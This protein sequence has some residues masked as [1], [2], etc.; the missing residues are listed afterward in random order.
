MADTEGIGQ[1]EA[2]R[3]PRVQSVAK[4][5]EILFAIS[6]SPTGLRAVDVAAQLGLAKQATYHLLHTLV[7]TGMLTKAP[8]NSYLLG[9]RIGALVEAFSK[10]L[11]PPERLTP[12]VREAANATG[13]T[14][15]A[16]GWVQGEIATLAVARGLNAIQAE[17][18]HGFYADAH[19]RA[20]GKLMLALADDYSLDRYLEGH[21]LRRRTRKTITSTSKL[22]AELQRIRRDGYAFDSEEYVEGLFCIAVPFFEGAVPYALCLSGPTDR[23][24]GALVRLV[25]ILRQIAGF[26]TAKASGF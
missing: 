4:A 26:R 1:T 23:M 21:P 19:S 7:T 11:A 25:E 13:E 2:N 9:L 5:V 17:V 6:R 14:A 12:F 15:Y 10:H 18:P 3:V 22:R 20:S 8:N 24:A 16:V